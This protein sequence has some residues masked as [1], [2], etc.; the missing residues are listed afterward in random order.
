MQRL[1]HGDTGHPE[2]GLQLA[3]GRQLRAGTSSPSKIM[4][5]SRAT[6]SSATERPPT[7]TDDQSTVAG[8]PPL[9]FRARALIGARS[10]PRRLDNALVSW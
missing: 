9:I 1:A 4:R 8:A 2:H 7:R 5:R 10:P 6:R 3:F